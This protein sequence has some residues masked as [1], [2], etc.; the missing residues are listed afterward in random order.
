MII[1]LIAFSM[2]YNINLE[3]LGYAVGIIMSFVTAGFLWVDIS[4]SPKG[5]DPVLFVI[6]LGM[7]GGIISLIM[8]A[9]FLTTTHSKYNKKGSKIILTKETRAKLDKY[10]NLYVLDYFAIAVLSLSFFLLKKIG[11]DTPTGPTNYELFFKMPIRFFSMDGVFFAL[12]VAL[13]LSVLILTGSLLYTA[14]D[15]KKQNTKQ[16]YIPEKGIEDERKTYPYRRL[17]GGFMEDIRSF[18]R[19]VNLD[20]VMN[21]NIKR[22]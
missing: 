5:T 14:N 4:H 1:H 3:M 22:V 19:N 8:F 12:K 9:T 7:L 10:R 20:Y 16:V 2:M 21:Y 11:S 15:L 6:L 17:R 13:S 18:F